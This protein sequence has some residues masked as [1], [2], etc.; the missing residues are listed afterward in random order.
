MNCQAVDEDAADEA[1]P[2]AISSGWDSSPSEEEE[3]SADEDPILAIDLHMR[4]NT[5]LNRPVQQVEKKLDDATSPRELSRWR[6]R[7]SVTWSR[8]EY[9][10]QL[11]L[12]FPQP[13]STQCAELQCVAV[14]AN[15]APSA[16]CVPHRWRLAELRRHAS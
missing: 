7:P 4:V 6:R 2:D 10:R 5:R 11:R 1:V 9:R 15:E 3:G 12:P 16:H 13:H 8:R 14:A